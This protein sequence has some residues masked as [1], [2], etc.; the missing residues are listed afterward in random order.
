MTPTDS[1]GGKGLRRKSSKWWL[2]AL[3]YAVSI[4]CLIW[5]YRGFDWKAELPRLAATNWAWV[6]LA[7][8]GDIAVYC[9]QGW[10][11]NLLLRPLARLP[12]WKT[13]QAIYIGL[14]ANEV[15]PL[16][17][18]EVIRCYLQS[19]WGGLP[20]SVVISSAIIERLLDGMWLVLGFYFV[21]SSLKLPG[22]LVHGSQI[23][24]LLLVVLSA[25][26]LIAV[27]QRGH[28][29]A[30][31]SRSRWG[32]RLWGVVD[33]VHDMGRSRYFPWVVL[34]SLVYLSLQIVP[35]YALM[36]GYGMGLSAWS[37]AVV[38]VVLRLGSVPPQA[39]GNVGSFQFLTVLGLR[40][41]GVEKADSTGF[42]TLLFVVVTLPLWLAGF[43]ALL[44]TKMR[45]GEIRRDAQVQ[46]DREQPAEPSPPLH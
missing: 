32:S 27:F 3:G 31:V 9:C 41:C 24:T 7:V 15:L 5:V 1:A 38:L 10:R 21:S 20:F 34:L 18:G 26:L 19:R 43:I 12:L 17:T 11:W 40:L 29:R 35:I 46:M 25:L 30:A 2:P 37:A 39:P 8:I 6:S 23:L 36:R 28:A 4:A 42:A 44:A 14:F 33:G 16:R 45:L 22:I 13:I